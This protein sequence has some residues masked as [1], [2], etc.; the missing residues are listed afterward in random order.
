MCLSV[1]QQLADRLDRG[2][3]VQPIKEFCARLRQ[4]IDFLDREYP[5]I[6]IKYVEPTGVFGPDLIQELSKQWNV[7]VNFMCIGS[8]GDR[9]PY[10]I[11]ELGGVRLII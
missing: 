3:G 11:E 9:F 1:A 10:R 5:K 2:W 8:P 4:D 6:D 7:P